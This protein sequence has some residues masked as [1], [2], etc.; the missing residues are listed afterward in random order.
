MWRNQSSV[1]NL[2]GFPKSLMMLHKTIIISDAAH[3][4]PQ[5][6]G[7]TGHRTGERIFAT[8]SA[9]LPASADKGPPWSALIAF[10]PDSR[11]SPSLEP[12]GHP[13]G[14]GGVAQAPYCTLRTRDCAV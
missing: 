2:C 3:A 13:S 11:R 1:G 8:G 14:A 6:A 12:P 4:A 7:V 5:A 10:K 9:L